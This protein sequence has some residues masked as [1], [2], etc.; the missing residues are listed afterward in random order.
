[1]LRILVVSS[2][3]L[4]GLV[5]FSVVRAEDWVLPSENVQFK[6]GKGVELV[7]SNCLSCHSSEYVTTQ[8]RL[9]REQWKASVTKMQ[10]KFGAP[11]SEASLEPLVE[12]LAGL[13]GR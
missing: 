11:I 5:S 10:T 2:Y 13:Y 9:T 1:M 4:S 12:Y 7:V 8:P 3:V 6:P